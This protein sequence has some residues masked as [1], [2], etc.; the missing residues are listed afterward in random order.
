MLGREVWRDTH[1]NQ[2][3][4]RR[5]YEENEKDERRGEEECGGRERDKEKRRAQGGKKFL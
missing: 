4:P 2:P 5:V 1:E 3:G